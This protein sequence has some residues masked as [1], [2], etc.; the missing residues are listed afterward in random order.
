MSC[1]ISSSVSKNR[2]SFHS[3]R[4][5]ATPLSEIESINDEF[6]W[7]T[8]PDGLHKHFVAE[9]VPKAFAIVSEAFSIGKTEHSNEDAYFISERSFGIADGVSGWVDFGF[10]SQAFS[11][12]LMQNC[13]AEIELF[14]RHRQHMAEE[15]IAAK[16]MR[17]TASFMSL[18][19]LDETQAELTERTEFSTEH[20]RLT[21]RHTVKSSSSGSDRN[22]VEH[23]HS[24]LDTTFVLEQA[25]QRIQ[26]VGSST[27]VLAILNPQNTLQISNLGDSGFLLYHQR[28]CST[29]PRAGA[30]FEQ[31]IGNTSLRKRSKCQTH[32]FNIPYQMS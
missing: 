2:N 32:S 30:V 20:L 7:A 31:I 9:T 5:L 15:K 13:Q 27:A 26:A 11:R 1:A 19:M 12:Q 24:A 14:D 8:G 4:I 3:F 10:S 22:K 6:T 21:S 18:E 28:D 16:H 25:S 29:V 17:K 23:R